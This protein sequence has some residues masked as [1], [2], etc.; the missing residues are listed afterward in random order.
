MRELFA[1]QALANIRTTTPVTLSLTYDASSSDAL[2]EMRITISILFSFLRR[3]VPDK[4]FSNDIKKW[5]EK[6]SAFYVRMA[7]WQDHLF[8]IYHV[9][10]CPPGIASWAIPLIQLPRICSNKSP[11]TTPFVSDDINHCMTF[12]KALLLPAKQRSEF[13]AQLHSNN[14]PIDAAADDLWII[15]DSDGE[16]D[17]TNFGECATLKEND[18]I[19]LLNQ[20]PFE[21]IFRFDPTSQNHESNV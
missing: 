10:R 19:A 18:L 15:I 11:S 7:T 6:L 14:G 16:E 4:E 8:L 21:H 1:L 2:N 20:V 5:L 13:L 3:Q 12:L 9:L 17:N